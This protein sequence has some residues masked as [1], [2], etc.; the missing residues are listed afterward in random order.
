MSV[1]QSLR[2]AL[3]AAAESTLWNDLRNTFFLFEHRRKDGGVVIAGRGNRFFETMKKALEERPA[4]NAT[5]GRE[6][7]S[8]DLEQIIGSFV[9]AKYAGTLVCPIC[10]Q[11]DNQNAASS[12]SHEGK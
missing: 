12:H 5:Q 6:R 2:C 4:E 1:L 9:G 11:T 10:I 8:A 7:Y 3:R